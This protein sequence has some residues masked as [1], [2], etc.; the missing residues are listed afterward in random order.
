MA[1]GVAAVI[2]ASVYFFGSNLNKS[3]DSSAK[4][5]STPP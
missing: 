4:A 3:L 1:A 2:I 5:L